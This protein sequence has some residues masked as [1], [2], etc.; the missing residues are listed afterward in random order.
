[1]K[2]EVDVGTPLSQ[3]HQHA[4]RVVPDSAARVVDRVAEHGRETLRIVGMSEHEQR[5]RSVLGAILGECVQGVFV[6]ARTVVEGLEI[7][8]ELR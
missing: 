7:R 4:H 6:L 2:R 1:M 8:R 3:R 5:G